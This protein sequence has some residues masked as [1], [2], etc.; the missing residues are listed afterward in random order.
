M[1]FDGSLMFALDKSSRFR[2]IWNHS[3]KQMKAMIP[4]NVLPTKYSKLYGWVPNIKF[5]IIKSVS[6]IPAE[7]K[8]K[9][10]IHDIK[11]SDAILALLKKL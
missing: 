3:G 2:F 4:N 7:N 10:W 11:V 8:V 9:S 6:T 5:E 1:G